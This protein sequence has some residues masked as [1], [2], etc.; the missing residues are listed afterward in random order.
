MALSYIRRTATNQ[1]KIAWLKGGK[2]QR[3]M[4]KLAQFCIL[5]SSNYFIIL[6]LQRLQMYVGKSEI[7]ALNFIALATLL[8][9]NAD[10][11]MN[12]QCYCEA[13]LP[14]RDDCSIAT[15][16]LTCKLD[17]FHPVVCM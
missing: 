8:D 4:Q 12:L 13:V 16:G 3:E 10:T 15:A 6:Q 17:S 5:N 7:C 2:L 9:V 14:L 1:C 11:S